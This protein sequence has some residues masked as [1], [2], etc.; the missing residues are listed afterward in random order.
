MT[1]A[2]QVKQT[3]ASLKSA[4]AT[5]RIYGIQSQSSEAKSIFAEALAITEEIGAEIE[6]RLQVLEFEEP[7]YKGL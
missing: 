4:Q 5:L 1:V 3:V 6:E 2:A 7:E